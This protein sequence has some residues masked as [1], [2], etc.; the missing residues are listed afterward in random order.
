MHLPPAAANKV[1]RKS[2]ASP[3][4]YRV[5]IAFAIYLSPP[6]P[7]A[8]KSASHQEQQEVFSNPGMSLKEEFAAGSFDGS[9]LE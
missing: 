3:A 9:L 2:L 6:Y 4:P 7:R 5:S 8:H 1:G